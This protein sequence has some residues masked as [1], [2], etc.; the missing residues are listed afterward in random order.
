VLVPRLRVRLGLAAPSDADLTVAG[1][2]I[3]LSITSDTTSEVLI[4]QCL[5]KKRA[6]SNRTHHFSLKSKGVRLCAA[7]SLPPL[8]SQ[9]TV[10]NT[11]SRFLPVQLERPTKGN[12][13]MIHRLKLLI[14]FVIAFAPRLESAVLTEPTQFHSLGP[15]QP[16][17]PLFEKNVGQYKPQVVF[18]ARTRG[19]TAFLT[20]SETVLALSSDRAHNPV[21]R[22][23][24]ARGR[25]SEFL[26]QESAAESRH[27]VRAD[28]TYAPPL[29][30][31]VLVKDVYR[32]TD[33]LYRLS[34]QGLAFDVH[35]QPG[36]D[37][38]IIALEVD[39]PGPPSI[40]RDGDLL[41][42]TGRAEPIVQRRPIA[43]QLE[44]GERQPVDA[45]YSIDNAGRVRFILG[46][47]DRS[48]PLIIDPVLTYAMVLDGS[49]N[50]YAF[51]VFVDVSRNVYVTGVTYS[52]D[53]PTSPGALYGSNQA[54][55]D[56][57]SEG[58]PDAFVAKYDASG[59]R[60]FSTYLGG[61]R[62]DVGRAVT[63]DG[64][65][66]IYVA[67]ETGPG[68]RQGWGDAG[69]AFPFTP[70]AYKCTYTADT[71]SAPDLFIAKLNPTGSALLFAAH[72]AGSG[73][74]HASAIA[75]DSSNNVY[76]A[77]DARSPHNASA[78]PTTAGALQR[79]SATATA[80]DFFVLKLNAAGTA[81]IY[82]TLLGGQKTETLNGMA[83]DSTGAAWIAGSTT[84]TDMRVS[85][86]AYQ[87]NSGG[88]APNVTQ[89]DGYLAKINPQGTALL[90]GTYLG[91]IGSDEITAVAVDVEDNVYI[92]GETSSS[93]FPLTQNRYSATGPG[94]FGKVTAGGSLELLSRVPGMSGVY[95]VAT[96]GG[97]IYLAGT[98]NSTDLPMKLAD[99]S[100]YNGA[101][102][103]YLMRFNDTGTA[104]EYSTWLG[105]TWS[106]HTY[107]LAVDA[108]GNAWV[109]G[110][111]A[112]PDFPKTSGPA[113]SP[114]DEASF[115]AKYEF[116]KDGDGL[117]D[118]WETSGIDVD[119]DG[120]V[121]LTLPGATPDHKD[122]FVEVDY[123]DVTGAD[124]HTHNPL[125]TPDRTVL[126]INPMESVKTAFANAPV[127]NPDG[128]TG[129]RLHYFV[130][131]AI[132][133]T[134]P[135]PWGTL[136]TGFDAIKRGVP[137]GD[138]T[139]R[140][141][142]S[143]QRSDANC[144]HILRAKRLAYRY[145]IFAHTLA[146]P[147]VGNSG[148]AERGGNDFVVSLSTS[149]PGPSHR[150]DAVRF[151]N[152]YGTTFAEEWSDMIAGTFMHE[153]GHTLQLDHGGGLGIDVGDRE[154]G[155]KPNYLSVMNYTRQFNNGGVFDGA[156]SSVRIGRTLDYSRSAL[157]E[158][159]EGALH[160]AFGVG[161]PAGYLVAFGRGGMLHVAPSDADID[162]NGINGIEVSPI[163]Q[164]INFVRTPTVTLCGPSFGQTL[165]GHD[166]WPNLVFGF[167]G[168]RYFRNGVPFDDAE[169]R[170]LTDE[171]L[172]ALVDGT[173]PP[174]VAITAPTPDARVGFASLTISATVTAGDNAIAEV[175]FLVD[176]T[177][178][179]TD[180]TPPYAFTWS[181]PT[182][183]THVIR[184]R[185]ADTEGVFASSTVRVHIGCTATLTPSSAS[186][187]SGGG[188]GS[189]TLTIGAPCTWL[190][191]STAE[192][193]LLSDTAGTG[194]ATPAYTVVAN[195][196]TSARAGSIAI[197]DQTF[198][199]TQS[200]AAPFGAPSGLVATVL[201]DNAARPYIAVTW[202][203][204]ADTA[205]YDVSVQR[206]GSTTT[207]PTTEPSFV[208]SATETVNGAAYL[209]K[210]R[211]VNAAATL[212]AYSAPDLATVVVFADD[213]IVPFVTTAKLVH[214]TELRSAV[215]A[216]RA[217]AGLSA[218]TWTT[219]QV[220]DAIQAVPITELRSA[221]D[222][223]RSTLVLPAIT[224][225]DPTLS[226]GTR[227]KAAHVQELRNGTK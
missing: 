143:G 42:P 16:V 147:R 218:A 41:I 175:T 116:D 220:G 189:I 148:I 137:A 181:A 178:I 131:E 211:A 168:S 84:S 50:D 79:R 81:L 35:L 72:V 200:A 113:P 186:I 193:I 12:P 5:L 164:D 106:D 182:E 212:S 197:N 206:A 117:F 101:Y 132:P 159:D 226:A 177:L 115:L 52:T 207:I 202:N 163:Q 89:T 190:A 155:C 49:E 17:A 15:L 173:V 139:G 77:G 140:F 33:V 153:L 188:S 85:P 37:P 68:R 154:I 135:L 63:V 45:R 97:L 119:G 40:T 134:T 150:A 146:H 183:G 29:F 128:T 83:I 169:A 64:S 185:A 8:T 162:W 216:V 112:S 62:D 26:G 69:L 195:P 24:F 123:M 90:Y 53:F 22:F 124:D 142:T 204:V 110:V 27:Y 103:A 145:A 121:D 98:T 161:G 180:T 158:L 127:S 47:Y 86:N 222:A 88:S 87:A 61:K 160:E 107:A 194:S 96:N 122:L 184:V 126:A 191:T 156:V 25:H 217:L 227:I 198:T 44:D 225:V 152:E 213:P 95:G 114:P 54:T 105:G 171:D 11:A 100:S 108:L 13:S 21:V 94:F 78:F 203:A 30:G 4:D 166:D 214:I 60:L 36:S 170:E 57:Y 55:S 224:Y 58:S 130:D 104:L 66:N 28:A 9:H 179:G 196:T 111:T 43:F 38:S 129:I 31:T 219:L 10:A 56:W 91:G 151:T 14:A 176:E 138:C 165:P 32:G 20:R 208:L 141:G 172:S 75:V 92:A 74:Q 215:N 144:K 59:N 209:F 102:D 223:A 7:P 34:P 120:T 201:L 205:Y 23:R 3:S 136:G 118:T 157:P 67:G 39:A 174:T 73:P 187:S 71:G 199:V 109:A 48:R 192:W 125:R 99:D 133:E 2:R 19:Y 80:T 1:L 6:G 18:A 210:A 82:S 76:V 221:L 93:N 65:G 149:L 51:D 46:A 70:G 167:R